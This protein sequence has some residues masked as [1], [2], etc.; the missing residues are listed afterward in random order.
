MELKDVLAI[1]KKRFW[2]ILICIAI[3]TITTA[4]YSK[5]NYHPIYIASTK[6]IVNKTVELDQL[7]KEQMDIGAI[8][9]NLSLINTYKEIIRSPA[10]MDKVVQRFPDL[11]VTTEELLATISISNLMGTQVIT[12][13]ATDLNYDRAARTVNAVTEVFRTEI[14]KIMKVDN[15]AIL[16]VAPMKEHPQPIN[17]KTNQYIIISFAV[18]LLISAGIIFLLEVMDDTLKREEDIRKIFGAPTLSVI[19]RRKG[20]AARFAKRKHNQKQ[21]GEVVN[22][23][24]K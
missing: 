16:H 8:G 14:T 21:V 5:Y 3:S 6:L 24:V 11:N 15:V 1:I 10:I 22:V 7:G 4:I 17:Q 18:S 2:L 19:P 23:A 9:S 20:E 12:L 13:S